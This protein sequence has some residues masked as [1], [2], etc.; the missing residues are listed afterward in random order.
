MKSVIIALF[1]SVLAGQSVSAA[2]STLV[3]PAKP[4]ETQSFASLIKHQASGFA[5]WIYDSG[6]GKAGI[7]HA[8]LIDKIL[9]AKFPNLQ[10]LV[11]IAP[12]GPPYLVHNFQLSWSG[13]FPFG[14]K[15]S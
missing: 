13:S 10:I 9:L 4:G 3:A 12:A 6:A 11:I 15:K 2:D 14:F 1:L 5:F 8:W 7:K